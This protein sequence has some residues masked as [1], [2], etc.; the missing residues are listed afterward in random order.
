MNESYFH[1]WNSLIQFRKAH[2]LRIDCADRA[3]RPHNSGVA[4]AGDDGRIQAT[5]SSPPFP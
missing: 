3:E 1:D 4:G 2:R 5:E